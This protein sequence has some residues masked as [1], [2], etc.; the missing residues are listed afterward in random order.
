MLTR[1]KSDL[2]FELNMRLTKFRTF[3]VQKQ[4][5]SVDEEPK[6]GFFKKMFSF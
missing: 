5:A 1:K 3:R 2:M 6:V 4:Q